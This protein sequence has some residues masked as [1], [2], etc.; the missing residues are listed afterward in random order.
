M[1]GNMNPILQRRKPSLRE[2][3]PLAQG[4]TVSKRGSWNAYWA[5]FASSLGPGPLLPQAC[6]FGLGPPCQPLSPL[7]P[8]VLGASLTRKQDSQPSPGA[9]NMIFVQHR[10][11][12]PPKG[13]WDPLGLMPC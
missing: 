10:V 5:C 11:G 13:A 12:H 6:A 8:A 1:L 3:K 9:E 7:G 4:H 2:V